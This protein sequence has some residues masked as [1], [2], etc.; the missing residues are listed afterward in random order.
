[1]VVLPDRDALAT[2]GCSQIRGLLP[3]DVWRSMPQ[4]MWVHVFLEA[5]SL[6]G[7]LASVPDHLV[8]IGV[9]PVC[10]RCLETAKRLAC[11]VIR[12]VSRSAASSFGL[13]IT[14]ESLRPLPPWT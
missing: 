1:M 11:A 14:S 10:Q 8:V 4:R 9:S 3:V 13:S 6:S 7:F 2:S 5:R 12:A